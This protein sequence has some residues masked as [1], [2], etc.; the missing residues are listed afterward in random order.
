MR[1]R[2]AYLTF[3]RFGNAHFEPVG[4][5]ADQVVILTLLAEKDGITQREVVERSYSD[6][7]T[8][9]AMLVRLEKKNLI[10]REPHPDDGRARCVYLTPQGRKLQRRLWEGW[11]DYLEKLDSAFRP[12]DL[13]T[14][15]SLLERVPG[16]VTALV[17]TPKEVVA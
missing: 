14:L 1:L 6:P 3:H 7:N 15:R 12:K 13:E 16:I 5:T 17:D 8:I 2:G 9:A 10:R 4:M 11:E